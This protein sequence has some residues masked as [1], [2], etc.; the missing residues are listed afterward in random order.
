MYVIEKTTNLSV[1]ELDE[2]TRAELVRDVAYSVFFGFYDER[3]GYLKSQFKQGDEIQGIYA[4]L[5][6][7]RDASDFMEEYE[8]SLF[9][10]EDDID[11]NLKKYEV[12]YWKNN[13]YLGLDFTNLINDFHYHLNH[14]GKNKG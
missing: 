3:K 1:N 13:P 4:F 14:L 9:S 6:N 7:I 10:N 2:K 11:N 8:N 12:F 5:E